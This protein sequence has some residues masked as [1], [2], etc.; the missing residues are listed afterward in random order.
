MVSGKRHTHLYN[1]NLRAEATITEK[2]RVRHIFK[3]LKSS[4]ANYS[5]FLIK[6]LQLAVICCMV[7]HGFQFY[8]YVS[9]KMVKVA[10]SQDM[11]CAEGVGVAALVK[12]GPRIGA[13]N[14]SLWVILHLHRP[15]K[16]LRCKRSS[17]NLAEF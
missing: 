9:N 3:P 4:F 14:K 5:V 17:L 16:K 15:R 6:E 12:Y 1:I 2:C 8:A 11:K 7:S 13:S 10:A